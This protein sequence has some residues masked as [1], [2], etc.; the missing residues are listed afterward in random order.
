[1]PLFWAFRDIRGFER[2]LQLGANPNVVFDDGGTIL[3]WAVRNRN[4][5]FLR[6]SVEYGGDMNKTYNEMPPGKGSSREPPLFHSVMVGKQD[7]TELL[8]EL[9]ADPNIEFLNRII[10]HR[11]A[12]RGQFKFLYKSLLMGGDYLKPYPS[13]NS[14]KSLA[15][16]IK[17]G[18]S[19]Y[20]VPKNRYNKKDFETHLPYLPKVKQFLR[21]R[22][23]EI[24]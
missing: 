10:L 24:K 9:G 3:N 12:A 13:R 22:G 1:V 17:L 5:E 23:V 18:E 8:L 15:D 21:D 4:L 6:L 16:L 19:E 11:L 20:Q 14:T 2:L 7:A